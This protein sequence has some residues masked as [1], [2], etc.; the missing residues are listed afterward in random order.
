MSAVSLSL[1][2]GAF[3]CF[4][5]CCAHHLQNTNGEMLITNGS[6]GCLG[7]KNFFIFFFLFCCLRQIFFY[8]Q[9][10]IEKNLKELKPSSHALN[11]IKMRQSRFCPMTRCSF[12][13]VFIHYPA[14]FQHVNFI[15]LFSVDREI[16]FQSNC[17]R[18]Q[19]S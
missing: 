4:R 14:L 9:I 8:P 2:L 17:V 15:S 7:L 12:L 11:V 10:Q 19:R 3:K 18:H 5:S 6:G 16:S 13:L 1:L